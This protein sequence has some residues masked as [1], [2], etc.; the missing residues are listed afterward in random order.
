VLHGFASAQC[1]SSC[2][3]L[4]EYVLVTEGTDLFGVVCVH[5]STKAL[6]NFV[7]SPT[8]IHK[9]GHYRTAGVKRSASE[10]D[11]VGPSGAGSP[12]RMMT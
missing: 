8:R 11:R 7:A 6:E 1:S 10:I 3:V 9:R 2:G 12:P 5:R 4:P